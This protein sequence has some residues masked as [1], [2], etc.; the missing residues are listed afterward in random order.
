MPDFSLRYPFRLQPGHEIGD[1]GKPMTITVGSRE[2]SLRLSTKQAGSYVIKIAGFPTADEAS[3]FAATMWAALA[4]ILID[5]TIPFDAPFQVSPVRYLA[6]PK[7]SPNF[8]E[9]GIVHGSAN[10]DEA[11]AFPSEQRIAVF[12]MGTPTVSVSSPGD[13]FLTDVTRWASM[14]HGAAISADERLRT[15]I[16]LY[17]ASFVES[18]RRAR[19]LALVMVLEVLSEHQMKHESALAFLDQWAEE[20]EE[21][22][23][24]AASSDEREAFE[25]LKRELLFRRE[26]SIRSRVRSLVLKALAHDPDVAKLAKQAVDAYDKRGTLVHDGTVDE[27]ELVK[28]SADVRVVVQKVLR[29]RVDSLLAKGPA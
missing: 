9:L 21:A 1:D 3:A 14:P 23:K 28:A 26:N 18:S 11:F 6:E 19:F 27:Q 2:L 5:L 25:S 10:E 15:A 12:G 20:I 13:R 29:A 8:P 22:R 7:V 16:E 17:S 4:N 24:N